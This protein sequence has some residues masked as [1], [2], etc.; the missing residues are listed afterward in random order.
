[1][2]D[3][4]AVQGVDDNA[5]AMVASTLPGLPNLR[6]GDADRFAQAV[7]ALVERRAQN[8]W[9]GEAANHDFAAF[10]LVARPREFQKRYGCKSLTDPAATNEPLLGRMMLLTR[11]A[12]GGQALPMPCT[13]ADLLDW[14]LD[15]GF[16]V[17]PVVLAYRP[18]AVLTVRRQG[19]AGGVSWDDPIRSTPPEATLK[20]LQEALVAF[21]MRHLLIPSSCVDGVWELGR[22]AAYVPG[23]EPEKSIQ[24]GLAL[25]LT[26]WFRGIILANT[27]DSRNIGRID[28]RLMTGG[29]GK[30]LA[31][32]AIVELKLIKSFANAKAR[33]RASVVTRFTNIEAVKEGLRQAWAFQVNTKVE[34]GLLEI[35]DLRKDKEDDLMQEPEVTALLSTL[36]PAPIHAVRAVYGSAH[37]ARIAGETGV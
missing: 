16:G 31:Y 4:D 23:E 2:A 29:E 34:H 30:P 22:A 6:A 10:V 12:A 36:S 27:E 28:I 13:Q 3:D 5:L 20:E 17:A 32:W 15:S 11:D 25:A 37:D 9:P 14:L 8:G 19:V 26:N 35:F 7:R 24:K 1:M 18:N 21:R 33:E